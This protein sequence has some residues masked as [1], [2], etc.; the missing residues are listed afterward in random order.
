MGELERYVNTADDLDPLIR[1][2]IIH[3]QFESIHPF[4]DG[5]GRL[6]RMLNVLYLTKEG[7]LDIPILYMSRGI[8]QKKADYY[9]LLQAVRD[10]GAWEEWVIYILDIV[11]ETSKLTLNLIEGIREQITLMD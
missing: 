7:L 4:S 1:M 11:D 10:D 9:R 6:G 8:N 3:H 5:N 2:A